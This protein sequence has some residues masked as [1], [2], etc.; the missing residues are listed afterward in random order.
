MANQNFAKTAGFRSAGHICSNFTILMNRKSKQ[1]RIAKNIA[2]LQS[3]LLFRSFIYHNDLEF[4][5]YIHFIDSAC[6]L[7]LWVIHISATVYMPDNG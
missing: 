1:T 2:I 6:A 5:S 4:L 3:L 7:G